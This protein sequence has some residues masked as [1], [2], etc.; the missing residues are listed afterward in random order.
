VAALLTIFL[1]AVRLA[2]GFAPPGVVWAAAILLVL[3]LGSLLALALAEGALEEGA[4]LERFLRRWPKL[5]SLVEQLALGAAVL[6]SPSAAGQAAAWSLALWTV[7]AGLYWACGRALGL[8]NLL[9]FPRSV[10]TLSWAATSSAL[11]AAPGA[12]GAFEAVVASILMKF[13]AEPGAGLAYAMVCHMVM[14]LTVTGLGLAFLSRE[15]LTL[16]S[17]REEVSRR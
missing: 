9:D 16:A 10:L 5:H 7:D 3:A 14:Y 12:I 13:G 17:L 2:P 4:W 15:G 1:V 8:G 6:R 11:P